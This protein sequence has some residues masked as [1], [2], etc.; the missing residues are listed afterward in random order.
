MNTYTSTSAGYQP[1]KPA[2]GRFYDR[3]NLINVT[4]EGRLVSIFTGSWLVGAAISQVDK[5][6]LGSLLKILTAGYL[7]YRGVSGNCLLNGFMGKRN[8]DRHTTAIN[9]RTT[10][11]I[12]NPKEE[13]YY[14]WRQLNNLPLFMKHL[15]SVE[16]KDPFHSH[17]VVKGPGGI[18]TLDWDAEI[19]KE[20]PGEMI[21]W[22]SLPGSS[23][24]TAG[25][26]AFSHAM[27]GGTTIDV[28]ITYRPPAG[29]VGTGLAWLLNPAFENMIIKDIRGFKHYMETGEPIV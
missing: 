17:W 12:D 29:Y 8:T 22:R 21:G 9:I 15:I 14:F 4:T 6:P 7:L 5:R 27:N 16:E 13:V 24:A 3:S 11:T 25:R 1:A 28:M 23:I 20:I 26:V 18:G 10:L 19:V 2:A